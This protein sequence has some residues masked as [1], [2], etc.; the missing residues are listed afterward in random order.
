MSKFLPH[1]VRNFQG[2]GLAVLSANKIRT[3]EYETNQMSE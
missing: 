1:L 3:V 2:I